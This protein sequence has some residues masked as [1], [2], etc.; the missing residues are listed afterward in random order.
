MLEG[1][2]TGWVTNDEDAVANNQNGGF[3]PE[4]KTI[5]QEHGHHDHD[6]SV[7]NAVAG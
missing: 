7:E 6:R 1:A 4:D 3:V 2:E 5:S